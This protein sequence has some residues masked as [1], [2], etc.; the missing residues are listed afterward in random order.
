MKKA[1]FLTL[2]AATAILL[3]ASC[4]STPVEK[5]DPAG[6]LKV[7]RTAATESRAKA[8]EIKADIAVPLLFTDADSTLTQAKKL[9]TA[10]ETETA[11]VEYKKATSMFTN[12]FNEAKLKKDAAIKALETTGKERI[13]AEETIQ[14]IET[15]QKEA[16]DE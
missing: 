3:V 16:G 15:E 10:N 4:A 11:L 12:A 1:P 6:D 8:L 5:L 2:L 9:D 7:V 14:A 13:L